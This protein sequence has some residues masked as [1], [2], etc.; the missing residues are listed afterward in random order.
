MILIILSEFFELIN[1]LTNIHMEKG[2]V[3]L[4]C[5]LVKDNSSNFSKE[6]EHGNNS[7]I[8]SSKILITFTMTKW[9][10]YWISEEINFF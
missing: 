2:V 8:I 6:V 10:K 1:L 5:L 3:T 4:L 9:E 7:L